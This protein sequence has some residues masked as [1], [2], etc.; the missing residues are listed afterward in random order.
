[1]GKLMSSCPHLEVSMGGVIVPCL[2]DAGSM[3]STI[4]ESILHHGASIDSSL[5]IGSNSERLMVWQFRILAI[6]S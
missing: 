1:M 5:V 6:L 4:T 2:V 3:V